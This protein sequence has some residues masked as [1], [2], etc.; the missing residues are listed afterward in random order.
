MAT[1]GSVTSSG[2]NFDIDGLISKLISI[3]QRA[4]TKLQTQASAMQSQVSTLGTL[5]AMTSTL[6]DAVS[7]LSKPDVWAS[8][9]VSST[10]SAV[11]VKVS[12]SSQ[13]MAGT[14]QV[15]V[16]QLARGQSVSS[17]ARAAT[18]G[19][20]AG[21][22]TL[23]VGTWSGTSGSSPSFAAGSSAAVDV[24][25]EQGDTLA[26]VASKINAAGA[27]V[28]ASV[29]T[30]L[31]GQRLV[32]RSADTGEAAGF[33][34]SASGSGSGTALSNLAFDAPGT[35]AGM[36]ANGVS[37]AANA[38]A[39]IDGIA[40]TSAS[41][42]LTDTVPGLTLTLSQVTTSPAAISTGT[43]TAALTTAVQGFV[44]AYNNLNTQIASLS[45][46]NASTGK[47]GLMQ[48]D[49]MVTGLQTMMRRLA[50]APNGSGAITTLSQLGIAFSKTAD[51][52]LTL[53]NAKLAQALAKPDDVKAFFM[54]PATTGTGS[55][56]TTDGSG[57]D[58]SSAGGFATRFFAFTTGVLGTDGSFDTRNK[59]LQEQISDN[60]DEQTRENDRISQTEA[61]LRLQYSALDAK[62]S[63]LNALNDYVKQQIT[64]WNKSN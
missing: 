13:A 40:V 21:T 64:T 59:S 31:S 12:D 24:A 43:D 44:N 6:S 39:N 50:G 58:S 54:G 10:S 2:T 53:D 1:T 36:A 46:Y 33:K 35:N 57:T 51:G 37:W 16:S 3:D 22:L 20:Q 17:S 26:T 9:T 56:G 63:T 5:K 52:S 11:G 29:I 61:R 62:L 18:D 55:T 47:A 25:I 27:G 4:V 42:T 8:K 60:S 15:S 34:V 7:A 14:L 38:M 48:G 23:Q 28:T 49:S 32:M 41:N 45:S 30:D 19:F